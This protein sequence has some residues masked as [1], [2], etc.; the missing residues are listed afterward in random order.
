MRL[1]LLKEVSAMVVAGAASRSVSGE[2][3]ARETRRAAMR[4]DLLTVV[5]AMVL[6]RLVAR[7][8][9]RRGEKKGGDERAARAARQRRV[10]VGASGCACLFR[11]V[12]IG[13]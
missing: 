2:G 8:S 7:S 9:R 13:H 4:F 6:A 11:S 3:P 10:G 1:D 5:S 12:L